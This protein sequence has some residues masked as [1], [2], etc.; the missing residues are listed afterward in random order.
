MAQGDFAQPIKPYLRF[1]KKINRIIAMP[2][3]LGGEFPLAGIKWIA[4]FPGNLAIGLKRAHSVTILNNVLTGEPVCVINTSQVSAIRT[5]SVSG[6]IVMNFLKARPD[7]AEFSIGFVGF[8]VIGQLHLD[9]LIALWGQRISKVYL[10][11][12]AVVG[13]KVPELWRD[14]VCLCDRW[15]DVYENSDIFITATV[16]NNPYINLPPK[17]GSLLLNVSLRDFQPEILHY[18]DKIIVDDWEEVCRE[19]TDIE[20]MHLKL[21]L[22]KSGTM[23]LIEFVNDHPFDQLKKEDVVMFNGM[24][25]AVFDIAIGG[26]YYRECLRLGVGAEI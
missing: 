8:G 7:L 14:K 10:Y 4:S 9:M 13:E 23:S 16:C 2:A 3:Y 5:A 6:F 26:F 17:P 11:D 19:N 12:I 18:V 20:R 25:M 1:G 15:E 22:E 24:G 21:G